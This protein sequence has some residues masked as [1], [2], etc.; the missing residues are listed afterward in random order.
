[1][2]GRCEPPRAPRDAQA[3]GRRRPAR[4]RHAPGGLDDDVLPGA[5]DGDAIA[6]PVV[7]RAIVRRE[8]ERHAVRAVLV[9]GLG[10]SAMMDIH[11][12][13]PPTPV[14]E[15]PIWP[16]GEAV[17]G[18]QRGGVIH[19]LRLLAGLERGA[20]NLETDNVAEFAH[21]EIYQ[22]VVRCGLPFMN[23]TP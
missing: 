12:P 22:N 2:D 13:G 6:E 17:D 20:L 4:P 16:D 9:L 1:M 21:N 7:H 11:E 14:P 18:Q 19:P 8:A 5:A 23:T 3:P 10:V 15:H